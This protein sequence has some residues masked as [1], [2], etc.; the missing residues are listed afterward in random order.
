[1]K[2]DQFCLTTNTASVCDP[3]DHTAANGTKF[4]AP[5]PI[6][7]AGNFSWSQPIN[8]ANGSPSAIRLISSS[9][10]TYSI[11]TSGFPAAFASS[12]TVNVTDVVSYDGYSGRNSVTQLNER[13]RI[14]FKK[15]GVQVGATPYT[16]DLPDQV[17]QGFWRGSLGSSILLPNGFDQIV[18]EHFDVANGS[19]GPGSVVPVSICIS[20]TPTGTGSI[21]DR[22]WYDANGNGIQDV[23]ET[24][25]LTGVTVKLRNS[26]GTVIQTTSTDGSGFYEFIGLAAGT[27]K[28]EFPVALN[29]SI[30]TKQ[31]Q[32]TNTTLDSDPSQSTGIT[33]E[34]VLASGQNITS[35][36]AGYC[37]ITL[38]VG[39][40][41]WIDAND[42]GIDNNGELGVGSA[43]VKLYKDDNN[44]NVADGAS[45]ASTTTNSTGNYSFGNL[46]PG[47]YIIG[48]TLPTGYR[49]STINGGDP[50]NNIDKDNNGI[51]LVGSEVRG[52]AI[53]LTGGGEPDGTNTNTDTNN[54]YDFG[55]V[56]T[57]TI[58]DRV[59]IDG[60][61]NGLQ[62]PDE[63][64]GLDNIT[65]R[66]LTSTGTFIKSVQTSSTGAYLFTNLAPGSYIVEFPTTVTNYTLSPQ[67]EGIDNDIDS[68]PA[69]SDG[70]TNAVALA[71]GQQITTVDAG[72]SPTNLGLGDRVWYDQNNNGINDGENGIPGIT[73]NLYADTDNDNEADGPSIAT[74]VTNGTGD[75]KF[76]NLLPGNYIVGVVIPAGYESSAVDGGDPD[77]DIDADDN[78]IVLVGNE[79]RGLAIT[80][81]GGTENNGTVNTSNTNITYDFGLLPDCDCTLH[82]GN[83]LV[84][85]DFENG[86]ANWEATNAVFTVIGNTVACGTHKASL[87][88]SGSGI[89]TVYQDVSVTAGATV[90]LNGFAGVNTAGLAGS[91][92]LMLQFLNSSNVVIETESVSITK[93]AEVAH[94]QLDYYSISAVAPVGA[95]KVRVIGSISTGIL[96]LDALCLNISAVPVYSLGNHVWYDVNNDG[97]KQSDEPLIPS[98]IVRLYDQ[99]G[100]YLNK[101]TVTNAAGLY[102]FTGL[103]AGMYQVGITTPAGYVKSTVGVTSISTDNQNDGTT[104]VGAEIRTDNFNLTAN[105][106]N[107]DFGLIGTAALGNFVWQDNNR[108]GIQETGEPGI[109]NVIVTLTLSNGKQLT[110]TTNANGIYGFQNLAPGTYS[111]KFTSPST[112]FVASPS[113]QGTNGAVDSDP[114][115]GTASNIVLAAG[116]LNNDID[117]GFYKVIRVSGN[118]WN[119]VNGMEDNLVNNSALTST[120]VGRVIP[121][122]L[123]VYLVNANTNKIVKTGLVAG[124]GTYFFNDVL[125]GNY[126]VVLS[127]KVAFAGQNSPFA[128]LPSFWINTGETVG[129]APGRDGVVNG[130]VSF[131]VNATDVPNVNFGIQYNNNDGGVN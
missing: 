125:A 52:F 85:A 27:Y 3:N 1:M 25:G 11:P 120:P 43:T 68:D 41:V 117:A 105:S 126:T 19:N 93:D 72:Y 90:S 58:G 129:L 83:Q 67:K 15:A 65:V 44:N 59:W 53:T 24:I 110:T 12:V 131:T 119:D 34:I 127:T 29:G 87:T 48:V 82:A 112:S 6:C 5:A 42:D 79:I 116:A 30:V 91:P 75:Y 10:L 108:N 60:N 106:T 102:S 56:P 97:T 64:A 78:G 107:I 33:G 109:P 128:T 69:T 84:N 28:V 57:G 20:Y 35:V 8:S 31:K 101:Q 130:K 88:P 21:G 86:T 92:S 98:V 81:A 22:V 80:L 40:R 122:G 49:K 100:D 103:P 13:W 77:N 123:R 99:N 89:A 18:L 26:A 7:S 95:T 2:A 37:P 51:N 74:Q 73:V 76:N 47:N 4:C 124:N 71:A 39:N 46:A 38:A 113:K 55:L 66:L 32:G 94:E 96:Y 36:D 14:V 70:R 16:T 50:D 62:D 115:G 61:G 118:V 63:T 23:A 54:T 9:A 17:N 45:I 114:V 104:I 121:T 111:V